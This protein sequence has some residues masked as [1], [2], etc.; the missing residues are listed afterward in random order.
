MGEHKYGPHDFQYGFFDTPKGPCVWRWSPGDK[1]SPGAKIAW[2]KRD[3]LGDDGKSSGYVIEGSI[4]FSELSTTPGSEKLMGFTI[5]MD[6]DDTPES[7]N[8]FSQ[9]KQFTWAGDK[10]NWTDPSKFGFLFLVE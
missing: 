4:P 9:D 3:D 6:D 7:I 5:G 2:K 8:P 10:F 1:L